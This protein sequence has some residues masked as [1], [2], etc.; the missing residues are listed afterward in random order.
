MCNKDSYLTANFRTAVLI[1]GR[2]GSFCLNEDFQPAWLWSWLVGER[3]GLPCGWKPIHKRCLH[4]SASALRI[5]RLL[6][7][8]RKK[9]LSSGQDLSSSFLSPAPL[10]VTHLKGRNL[11][12]D[13]EGSSA[14]W[15]SLKQH[16]ASVR[17]SHVHVARPWVSSSLL[18][19]SVGLSGQASPVQGPAEEKN[20]IWCLPDLPGHKKNTITHDS[21]CNLMAKSPVSTSLDS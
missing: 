3:E 13:E 21:W 5:L 10:L 17:T 20:K 1:R 8:S 7:Y 14:Q 6:Q 16:T 19:S 9:L 2:F 12:R 4:P 15:A 18:C 11:A